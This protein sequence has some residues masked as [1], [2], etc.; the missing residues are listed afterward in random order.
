MI[1]KHA[2]ARSAAAITSDWKN[3]ESA[4][5]TS[6]PVAPHDLAVTRVS[7]T[8]RWAPLALLAEP[9]RSRAD[10]ISGRLPGV[11][12]IPINALRPFTPV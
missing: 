8:R 5:R 1:E 4:R 6:V 9:L 11:L 7:D 2:L 10:A 3:A 12:M